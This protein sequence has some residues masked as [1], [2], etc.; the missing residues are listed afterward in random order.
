MSSNTSGGT[1]NTIGG[2]G[3]N[4]SCNSSASLFN[5]TKY[6]PYCCKI[7]IKS[8][9]DVSLTIFH[10]FVSRCS[11]FFFDISLKTH[12]HEQLPIGDIFTSDPYVIIQSSS[13][14]DN[15]SPVFLGRTT[16]KDRELN[17]G[18]L[19]NVLNK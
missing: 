8:A 12:A 19:C 9:T 15:D 4:S 1:G 6:H 11:C 17:P 18:N 14:S 10:L 16:T 5:S 7:S 3:N 2:T 13:D